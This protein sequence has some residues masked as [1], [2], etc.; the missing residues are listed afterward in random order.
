MQ[1]T[2]KTFITCIDRSVAGFFWNCKLRQRKFTSYV[3]RLSFTW[4]SRSTTLDVKLQFWI[5]HGSIH[6]DAWLSKTD[7]YF[8]ALLFSQWSD[9]MRNILSSFITLLRIR[10]LLL[11]SKFDYYFFVDIYEKCDYIETCLNVNP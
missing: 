1:T 9:E 5:L 11:L 3:A 6:T 8:I 10:F 2:R 4:N 7:C